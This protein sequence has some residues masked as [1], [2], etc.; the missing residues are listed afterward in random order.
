M[1]TQSIQDAPRFS[2]YRR[3]GA[4]LILLAGFWI[5]ALLSLEIEWRHNEQYQFGYFVPFFTLYLLAMRLR[6]APPSQPTSQPFK[7]LWLPALALLPLVIVRTANPD[8]R[9]IYLALTANA[10]IASSLLIAYAAG[11]RTLYH[12]LP[13]ALMILFAVPWMTRIENSLI[14]YLMHLVA[15]ITVDILNLMGIFAVRHGNLIQLSDTMVGVEEACSGIRSLQSSLMAGY[16]FGELFRYRWSGRAALIFVGA[17]L[18]F[19]LNIARTLSL[20]WITYSHGSDAFRQWHDPIGQAVA[21]GGF[22]GIW[23]IAL[24]FRPRIQSHAI[25]E[26]PPMSAHFPDP[27]SLRQVMPLLLLMAGIWILNWIWYHPL[28]QPTNIVTGSFRE[29]NWSTLAPSIQTIPIDAFTKAQLKY[30]SGHQRVWQHP[31]KSIWT[32]FHFYWESGSISSHAGVH[33]PENCLPSAGMALVKE[34]DPFIWKPGPQVTIPFQ[35]FTFRLY[36]RD[37]EVFFSVWNDNLSQPILSTTTRERL[38]EAWNGNRVM[39]RNSLEFI[40]EGSKSHEQAR[41]ELAGILQ[42]LGSTLELPPHP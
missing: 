35:S 23:I 38:I 25:R 26:H 40:V 10:L 32:A 8:W 24:C 17:I 4:S 31:N 7:L 19:L 13:A 33:R 41:S 1:N 18:T 2:G 14:Q 39:G 28:R 42:T 6:D 11:R 36:D 15:T 22:A 9:F 37:I 27:P 29:L 21:F 3:I 20:T 34:H 12:L 5:P 16:L 30:D